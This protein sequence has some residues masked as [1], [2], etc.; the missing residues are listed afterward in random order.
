[1][2]W[3]ALRDELKLVCMTRDADIV[4]YS[5][6]RDA[7]ETLSAKHMRSFVPNTD[8][9]LRSCFCGVIPACKLSDGVLSV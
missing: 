2:Y 9:K 3:K 7:C 1:M 4:S 6:V 5:H 8:I